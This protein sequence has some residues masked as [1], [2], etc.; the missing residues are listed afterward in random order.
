LN[1][2]QF[3]GYWGYS[4]DRQAQSGGFKMEITNVSTDNPEGAT[5]I[6]D[7]AVEMS[8]SDTSPYLSCTL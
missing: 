1:D 6:C 8:G 2:V 4:T 5:I 7:N 3:S